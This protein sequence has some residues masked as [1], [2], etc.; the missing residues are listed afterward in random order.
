MTVTQRSTVIG[1]FTNRDQAN[2]V[3]DALRQAGFGYDRIRLVERGSGNFLDTLKSLFTGQET[4]TSNNAND[5]MKMGMPEQDAHYYQRELDAGNV[6]VI[7]NAGEQPE[8]A[9]SIMRQNGAFD[10][11]SHMRM[12]ATANVP[13]G[14]Y[15][16]NAAREAYN[17]NAPAGTYNRP[18]PAYNP[19]MP[20]TGNPDV[21]VPPPAYNPNVGVSSGM[22]NPN[23][24]PTYNPNNPNNPNAPAYNPNV[25][26]DTSRN[27]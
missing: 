19:N 26:P 4:T 27:P 9:F 25:P 5:L 23:V 15:N 20:P 16:T 6:I 10:V 17:P 1:V 8:Q 12:A 22:Q 14:A 7:L 2:R 13:A 21:N 24:P 3:I 11:S 18:Q